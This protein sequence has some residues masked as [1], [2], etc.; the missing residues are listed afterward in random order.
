MRSIFLLIT[1]CLSTG[2]AY[3][4]EGYPWDGERQCWG[5][6]RE[7]GTSSGFREDTMPAVHYAQDEDGRYWR[8]PDSDHPDGF[9]SITPNDILSNAGGCP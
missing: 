3:S 4:V 9:T 1:V 7:A 2:C 5:A 8:F 6:M